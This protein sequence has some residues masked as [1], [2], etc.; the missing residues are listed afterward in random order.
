MDVLVRDGLNLKI[1]NMERNITTVR[2]AKNLLERGWCQGCAAKDKDGKHVDSRSPYA[3]EWCIEGAVNA[4]GVDVESVVRVLMG[5][6][7][8]YFFTAAEIN[9]VEDMTQEKAIDLTFTH[10][11]YS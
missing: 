9:D 7:D 3:V 8:V 6:R 5:I 1:G 4:G 2:N 10:R 11:V